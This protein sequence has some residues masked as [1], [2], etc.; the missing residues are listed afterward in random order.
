[1]R[2]SNQGHVDFDP[3]FVQIYHSIFQFPSIPRAAWVSVLISS[4]T[5]VFVYFL[6]VIICLRRLLV[7]LVALDCNLL[8]ACRLL[9]CIRKSHIMFFGC[10]VIYNIFRVE[11]PD[12][13]SQFSVDNLNRGFC[14]ERDGTPVQDSAKMT[15]PVKSAD[16]GF[17]L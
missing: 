3:C 6:V 11:I 7:A 1:M 10:H 5:Y 2:W 13:T 12:A 4:N 14:G 9:R 15:T 8:C 16:S 17:S